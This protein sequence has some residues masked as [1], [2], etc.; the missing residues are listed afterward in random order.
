MAL[1]LHCYHSSA[2]FLSLHPKLQV[3]RSDRLNRTSKLSSNSPKFLRIRSSADSNNQLTLRTCRNC[4]AQFDPSLNHPRACRFHTAHF[5]GETKRKFE[6]VHSGGTMDTPDSGKVFQ[7]WHCCG[8]ED[9]F[10]PGCTAS[11]HSS[12]DDD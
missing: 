9:P 3:I 11:P 12:Y 8:S 1:N 10:D 2:R 7:Y 6:S 5:G 4:K